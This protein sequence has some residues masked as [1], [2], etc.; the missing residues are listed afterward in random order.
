MWRRTALTWSCWLVCRTRNLR[1]LNLEHFRMRMR[2]E[3]PSPK[4]AAGERPLGLRGHAQDMFVAL[5][6]RNFP[7]TTFHSST[8]SEAQ[9]RRYTGCETGGRRAG[10]PRTWDRA[11]ST[12]PSGLD[13][14]GLTLATDAR[15]IDCHQ[16]KECPQWSRVTVLRPEGHLPR[17]RAVSLILTWGLSDDLEQGSPNLARHLIFCGL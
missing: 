2:S 8:S 1:K 9:R 10:F 5:M 17:G 7:Q 11:V 14:P 16:H 12:P 13:T 15:A 4:W 6:A 3:D